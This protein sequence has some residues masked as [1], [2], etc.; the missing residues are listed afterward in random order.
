MKHLAARVV[1]ARVFPPLKSL[2]V[3][4]RRL[5]CLP[6]VEFFGASI[7][8]AHPPGPGTGVQSSHGL[9][10]LPGRVVPGRSRKQGRP[11]RRDAGGELPLRRRN[12]FERCL[13]RGF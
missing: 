9:V 5:N 12:V 11:S 1:F 13:R 3:G 2:R 4:R 10:R 7:Q 6:N 8:I